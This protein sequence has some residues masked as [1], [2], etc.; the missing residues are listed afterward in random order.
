MRVPARSLQRVG[1]GR[2]L[3][4]CPQADAGRTTLYSRAL[5]HACVRLGGIHQFAVYID[6]PEW[7]LEA[8]LQG[9]EEVPMEVFLRAVDVI[10]GTP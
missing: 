5:H 10:V 7:R 6:V 8:W 9:R 4:L 3:Q 1:M 2:A